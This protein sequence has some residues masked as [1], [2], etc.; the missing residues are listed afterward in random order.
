MIELNRPEVEQVAQNVDKVARISRVSQV[1]QW[2]CVIGFVVFSVE[3]FGNWDARLDYFSDT[4]VNVDSKLTPTGYAWTAF[5]ARLPYAIF[6]TASF[7]FAYRTFGYFRRGHIFTTHSIKSLSRMSWAALFTPLMHILIT[8]SEGL[9]A[10][11]NSQNNSISIVINDAHLVV[12]LFCL[13]LV[14]LS[15]VL[16]EARKQVDDVKLIF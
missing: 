4:G 15:W 12:T 14:A 3:L 11:G 10:L 16:Q 7:F 1:V 9:L 5:V 6:V 13:A 2:M 8:P